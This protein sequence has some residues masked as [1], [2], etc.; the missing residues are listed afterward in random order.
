MKWSQK[1]EDSVS[2]VPFFV[3]KRVR[4]RIEEE[5]LRCG[6]EAVLLEHVRTCRK[7]FL[8]SMESE[9][10]GYSLETCFGPSGCPNQA[11]SGNDGFPERAEVMLDGKNLKAVLK[12]RVHGAL[13]IHHEFRV[14]ISDCPNACSRPQIADFGLIGAKRPSLDAKACSQC[15]TCM[16][17]CRESALHFSESNGNL[18]LEN[19]K[20]LA[21]GLCIHNCPTGA[22]DNAA[23]GYRILLGGKL[24]RHPQLAKEIQGIFS[25]DETLKIL[26]MCLEHFIE[27]NQA[28]ERFG[29]ILQRTGMPK[30]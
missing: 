1:A 24:G 11:V 22:L 29:D 8:S 13:K 25:L 28:G 7:S 27:H 21:C 6:A 4:K 18:Y 20:C 26:D 2:K 23:V 19:D 12:N 10:R 15:G 14:S 17:V 5:A 16:D 3:R 30:L 9:V